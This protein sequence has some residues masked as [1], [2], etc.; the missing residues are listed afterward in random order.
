MPRQALQALRCTGVDEECQERIMRCVLD[1]LNDSDWDR[2]PMEMAIPVFDTVRAESGVDD[3][4]KEVK[5]QSN[6]EARAHSEHVIDKIKASDDPI[7]VALKGAI[8]GNIIDYGAMADFDLDA[9]MDR[10][11]SM[12]FAIDDE[13]ALVDKIADAESIAYLAD[14][15]GEIV[16]D[17]ILLETISEVYG[18]KDVLFVVRDEPFMNDA[19][20]SDAR[21]AGIVDM[22][23]VEVVGM[24]PRIPSATDE[25]YGLWERIC[26]SDVVISKGQGNYE[27]FSSEEGIFFL[28]MTKCD[29]VARDVNSRTGVD[30]QLGDMILWRGRGG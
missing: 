26:A 17:R 13:R 22:P 2:S 30:L 25:S 20:E 7:Q 28:L 4:Y 29:L 21:E 12:D 14:N 8:G 23:D 5:R 11:F 1:V 24:P 16:F 27:A 15:A 18:P 10:V 9:T 3:P 6:R 19:L